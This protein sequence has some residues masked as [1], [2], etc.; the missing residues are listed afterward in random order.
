MGCA[1]VDRREQTEED[2]RLSSA[3]VGRRVGAPEMR[4][5]GWMQAKG[6]EPVGHSHGLEGVCVREVRFERKGQ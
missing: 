6:L 2:N 1:H 5:S 4:S 3:G